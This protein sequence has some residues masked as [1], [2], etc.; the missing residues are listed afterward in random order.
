V[1]RDSEQV[2]RAMQ[3]TADRQKTLA[4]HGVL[5]SDDRL[6]M[7]TL[8]VRDLTAIDGRILVTAKRKLLGA[9][10]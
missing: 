9:A 2:L 6:P 8:D 7:T 1:R 3:R 10:T 4:V 5:S